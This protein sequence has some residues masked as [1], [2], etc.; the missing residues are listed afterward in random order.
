V[1]ILEVILNKFGTDAILQGTDWTKD[2]LDWVNMVPLLQPHLVP[3]PVT[4]KPPTPEQVKAKIDNWRRANPNKFPND[5]WTALG[6]IGPAPTPIEKMKGR[7]LR[8]NPP[9]DSGTWVDTGTS[10]THTIPPFIHAI[11]PDPANK[12]TWGPAG[13]DRGYI[14]INSQ[15]ENIRPGLETA[16]KNDTVF[17]AKLT[18]ET[19]KMEKSEAKRYRQEMTDQ[20]LNQQIEAKLRAIPGTTRGSLMYSDREINDGMRNY[21][22]AFN[23]TRALHLHR[24]TKQ[25]NTE[26][27]AYKA[28]QEYYK[29]NDKKCPDGWVR[30]PENTACVRDTT[31]PPKPDEEGNCP[32]GWRTDGDACVKD[33]T[34]TTEPVVKTDP[35]KPDK[36]GKCGPGYIL[37]T[38][39]TTCVPTGTPPPK[40]VTEKVNMM[41]PLGDYQRKITGQFIPSHQA[42]DIGTHPNYG[43]AV[44]APEDGTITKKDIQVP[45]KKG[46]DAAGLYMKL[47]SKDGSREH[48]F[49]HLSRP[50]KKES[51]AVKQGD[52]IA[53]SGGL[54]R[55]F[56]LPNGQVRPAS[57]DDR[58]GSSTGLHLHWG[59]KEATGPVDPQK[60]F[61]NN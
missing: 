51:D 39:K 17:Q 34:T 61:N 31:K 5:A 23:F 26:D 19:E 24:K 20:L 33:E 56:T 11:K 38:D 10:W 1:K 16:I 59:V 3:D 14:P 25:A 28:A 45:A 18:A 27:A 41:W 47:L 55:E 42:I 60:Y 58:A 15:I 12:N 9:D 35:T 6:G 13:S 52:I 49:M 8:T 2:W 22:S 54:P 53:Y 44:L 46:D 37:S 50:N 4:K 30:N 7:D 29:K 43:V 40:P 36:D 48:I 21:I 32:P 57:Q